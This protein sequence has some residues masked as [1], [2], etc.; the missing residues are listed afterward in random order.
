M[1][2]NGNGTIRTSGT[3]DRQVITTTLNVRVHRIIEVNIK[4]GGGDVSENQMVV[5]LPYPLPF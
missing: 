2:L 4:K 1:R 5:I 3:T